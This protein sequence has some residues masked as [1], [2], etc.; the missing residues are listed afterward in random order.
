[1]LPLNSENIVTN[2]ISAATASGAEDSHA[3]PVVRS[4]PLPN[5]IHLG[6]AKAASTF[7]QSYLSSHPQVQLSFKSNFFA[8]FFDCNYAYG[9]E[10]LAN[11]F[12]HD[13]MKPVRIESD[14]HMIMPLLHPRLGVRAITEQSTDQLLDRIGMTVPESKLLL[15]LRNQKDMLLS[16]YSQYLLGGGSLDC[17]Q[18]AHTLLESD[19][20]GKHY[21]SMNF[22]EIIEKIRSRHQGPLMV[23]LL[24]DMKRDSQAALNQLCTF[25]EIDSLPYKESFKSRRRGLSIRS[26]RILLQLNR[27]GRLSPDGL[28]KPR[29]AQNR[30]I[31]H[32]MCN[33]L[34]VIDHVMISRIKRQPIALRPETIQ[35][36]HD[37]FS[38]DNRTL[39]EILGRDLTSLGY[40]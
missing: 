8:P 11:P 32:R 13:A 35:L 39:G 3:Q 36:I 21:F 16:T 30:G 33:V 26:Q 40:A 31:Y 20:D 34:R 25:L 14:E 4:L 15:I 2:S 28:Y 29:L 9:S 17:D 38:A 37:R 6:F 23:L 22:S 5:A 12:R 19:P 7:L 18:F 27:F 1:M 24:E 10:Q